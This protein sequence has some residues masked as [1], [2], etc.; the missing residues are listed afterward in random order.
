LTGG[1]GVARERGFRAAFGV[2]LYNAARRGYLGETLDS[3]LEQTYPHVGYALVDDCSDDETLDVVGQVVARDPRVVVE[4]NPGRL[5]LVENWRRA[6]RLARERFP[7]AVY[8]SWGSDHDRWNRRWLESLVAE[9]DGHPDAVMAYP[10]FRRIDDQ[11][12]PIGAP[13]AG[14]VPHGLSRRERFMLA[15]SPKIGAGNL[16]YGLYRVE[17]LERAGVYPL[18]YRPDIYLMIELSLYGEIRMV[19]R[20][21]WERRE[22]PKPKRAPRSTTP[23]RTTFRRRLRDWKRRL[24]RL[25][26]VGPVSRQHRHIFPGRVPLYSR[27]P[28]RLQ[29]GA[30]LFWRLGVRGRGR[31]H[32]GRLEGSRYALRL[33]FS[34]VRDARA[35]SRREPA[36]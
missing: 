1:T 11:G 34:R 6:F 28:T 16:V 7:E 13:S 4:Q 2:P 3:L 5:G 18:V 15:L 8:F 36:S 21:L 17:T 26:G 19:P 31:P 10:R 14:M 25:V 33:L 32:V 12:A 35:N 23:R 22:P 20:E 27:L 30:L 24:S 29:H 9:L